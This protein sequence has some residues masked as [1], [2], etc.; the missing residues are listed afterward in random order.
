MSA[1]HTPAALVQLAVTA[2]AQQSWAEA[3][4][5]LA[6]AWALLK[7]GVASDPLAIETG[8]SLSELQR[9]RGSATDQTKSTLEFLHET[10]KKID[11]VGQTVIRAGNAL[12]R[13]L[14]DAEDFESAIQI[15][16][17]SSV[18][19]TD[20]EQAAM[21]HCLLSVCYSKT[22]HM[23]QAKKWLK[24][25]LDTATKAYNNSPTL[26]FICKT[27]G[28]LAELTEMHG[29]AAKLLT[30]A[31]DTYTALKEV[32][33]DLGETL[34]GLGVV[35]EQLGKVQEAEGSLTASLALLRS[36]NP[37]SAT[38]LAVWS[39]LGQFYGRQHLEDQQT[40]QVL[41]RYTYLTQKD[42]ESVDAVD[43]RRELVS[44]YQDQGKPQEAADVLKAAYAALSTV[45]NQST[46]EVLT[47]LGLFSIRNE[48]MEEAEKHLK[49][50]YEIQQSISPNS[51]ETESTLRNLRWLYEQQSRFSDMEE[52]IKSMLSL[53]QSIDP[54]SRNTLM[55]VIDLVMLYLSQDNPDSAVSALEMIVNEL[56]SGCPDAVVTA[57][58]L[59]H[60]SWCLMT[61]QR[62][63]DSRRVQMEAV[64]VLVRNYEGE[65][66]NT[67][68][69]LV[70]FFLNTKQLEV[71]EEVEQWVASDEAW[72]SDFQ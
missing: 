16:L 35:Y 61:Q 29:D 47:D 6:Q 34:A 19:H 52:T 18:L 12:A 5:H 32:S 65:K 66:L 44:L 67:M 4:T 21:N 70:E 27:M 42:P 40:S 38:S 59:L 43:A 23:M 1:D 68:R 72:D 24:S 25:A 45:K 8:L 7:S 15:L 58:A 49:Q 22:G 63:E 39:S 2:R 14:I 10:I 26:A 13:V 53:H 20:S 17:Y 31:K 62:D 51:P 55:C 50:A 57:N 36:L 41:A 69:D 9:E 28:E 37:D 54:Y 3:E 71:S 56:K 60:L 48:Q 30:M 11:P 33:K 46:V 64:E